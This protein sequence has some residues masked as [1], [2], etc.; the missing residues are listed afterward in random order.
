MTAIVGHASR[1]LGAEPFWKAEGLSDSNAGP[2]FDGRNQQLVPHLKR[3]DV[4]TA[5]DGQA[6]P[7]VAAVSQAAQRFAV[8][9]VAGD[10]LLVSVVRDGAAAHLTIPFPAGNRP[11]F[12]ATWESSRRSGFDAVATCDL[13]LG[14]TSCGCPIY[15]LDGTFAGIG[16]ASMISS[17]EAMLFAMAQADDSARG[18]GIKDRLAAIPRHFSGAY[19]IPAA[20]VRKAL[21][22]RSIVSP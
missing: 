20:A 14:A 11:W 9:H 3:G 21:K 8:E 2:A 22:D 4:V 15:T 6:T 10:P 17:Q 12:Q 7:T 16:I 5:V 1:K 18:Q 19:F 13:A